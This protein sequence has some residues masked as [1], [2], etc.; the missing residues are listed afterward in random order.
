[1]KKSHRLFKKIKPRHILIIVL[2]LLILGALIGLL[3]YFLTKKEKPTPAPT[4]EMVEQKVQVNSDNKVI[5]VDGKF[6]RYDPGL[7]TRPHS[8]P[9]VD[10]HG[11]RFVNLDRHRHRDDDN[12]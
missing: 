7:Y 2:V 10:H 9:D 3:V 5:L 6:I 12:H 8:Y 11:P 1:M 4:Q